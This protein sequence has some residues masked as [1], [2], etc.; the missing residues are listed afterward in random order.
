MLHTSFP[1]LFIDN[2][3]IDFMSLILARTLG[4]FAIEDVYVA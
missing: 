1:A 2:N 3:E 4:N